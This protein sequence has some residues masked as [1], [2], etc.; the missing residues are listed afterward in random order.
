MQPSSDKLELIMQSI[1]CMLRGGR[2]GGRERG[3]ERERHIEREGLA[4]SRWFSHD[5]VLFVVAFHHFPC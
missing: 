2:E 5:I 1:S 4:S 3:R